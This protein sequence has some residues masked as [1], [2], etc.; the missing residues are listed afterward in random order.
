MIGAIDAT[1]ALERAAVGAGKDFQSC[2][3]T[4]LASSARGPGSAENVTFI[5]LEDET[6]VASLVV[7]EQVY[8][9]H[10]RTVLTSAMLGV[11]GRVQREA[12]WRRRL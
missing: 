9:K 1:S 6:G 11:V 3:V 12:R 7:W 2:K 4:G 5:T 10:R 8:E